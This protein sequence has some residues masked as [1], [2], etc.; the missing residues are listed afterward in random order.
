MQN[1]PNPF[2]PST[3]ISYETNINGFVSLKVYDA[4]GREI[5]TLVNEY[6]SAGNHKINFNGAQLPSGVYFYR[7]ITGGNSNIKKMSPYTIR[8]TFMKILI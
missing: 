7:L 4:L 6:Q 1:Y 5:N 8:V 2:N 3:T